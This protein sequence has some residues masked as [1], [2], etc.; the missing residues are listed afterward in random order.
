MLDQFASTRVDGTARRGNCN[1]CACLAI[2]TDGIELLCDVGG[3]TDDT[4]S[5]GVDTAGEADSD[6]DA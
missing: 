6:D 5:V 2:D 3:M 4:V 1:W